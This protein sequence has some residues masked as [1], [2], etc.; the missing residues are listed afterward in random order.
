MIAMCAIERAENADDLGE[1]TFEPK[2]C[3]DARQSDRESRRQAQR[4]IQLAAARK[5][6]DQKLRLSQ[7]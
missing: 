3:R 4:A 7:R 1:G 6:R 5:K 2:V